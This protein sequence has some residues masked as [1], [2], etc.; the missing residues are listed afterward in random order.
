MCQGESESADEPARRIPLDVSV[1]E[2]CDTD[3]STIPLDNDREGWRVHEFHPFEEWDVMEGPIADVY[4]VLE[5]D[6][7]TD[8][9]QGELPWEALTGMTME[10]KVLYWL[11]QHKHVRDNY[12][13][14]L[15]RPWEDL[16][17]PYELEKT[18]A[19][20][21]GTPINVLGGG[22]VKE[23]ESTRQEV[24]AIWF[25][26]EQKI[27]EITFVT[28]KIWNNPDNGRQDKEPRLLFKEGGLKEEEIVMAIQVVV[29][30]ESAC[31][32]FQKD[33]TPEQGSAAITLRLRRNGTHAVEQLAQNLNTGKPE[34]LL[35][36]KLVNP[37]NFKK[38][39]KSC[40]LE[41][42]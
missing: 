36:T 1:H 16:Q 3:A 5:I 41:L 22:E 20:L 14:S 37:C 42:D 4:T 35:N 40:I 24:Q 32:S 18:R 11:L 29:P 15:L 7:L 17:A 30:F 10:E 13:S 33:V 34:K 39:G 31:I 25:N 9:P 21:V 6:N 12:P 38:E 23:E 8:D 28:E 27:K 19:T 2:S 26:N